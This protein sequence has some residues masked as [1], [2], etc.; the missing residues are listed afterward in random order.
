M[1]D[2][3]TLVIISPILHSTYGKGGMVADFADH[4]AQKIDAYDGTDRE[5]MILDMCWNWFSGGT[6][7]ASVARK[8]EEALC[9]VG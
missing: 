8:I 2:Q 5:R 7:A 1:A 6:T 3:S 9:A 4:L